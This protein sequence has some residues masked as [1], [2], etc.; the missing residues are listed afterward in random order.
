MNP[1]RRCEYCGGK[2]PTDSP[3]AK[4]CKESCRQLAYQKRKKESGANN[5]SGIESEP[6]IKLE[7][8]RLEK[9]DKP[10]EE[11]SEPVSNTP[12]IKKVS[13]E[14]QKTQQKT[15]SSNKFSDFPQD[16]FSMFDDDFL[17][18]NKNGIKTPDAPHSSEKKNNY[19]ASDYK[20][21]QRPS[22][23]GLTID[24]QMMYDLMYGSNNDDL[25]QEQ[26]EQADFNQQKEK[27]N[28]NLAPV[29]AQNNS[30]GWKPT[31]FA[32]PQPIEVKPVYEIKSKQ[33]Y[34]PE[35]NRQ[36]EESK[37]NIQKL[38]RFDY[39]ENMLYQIENQLV[40][41]LERICSTWYGRQPEIS[42]KIYTYRLT[43]NEWEVKKFD[44]LLALGTSLPIGTGLKLNYIKTDNASHDGQMKAICAKLESYRSLIAQ[45]KKRNIEIHQ[46]LQ[47]WEAKMT[48]KENI[49]TNKNEFENYVKQFEGWKQRKKLHDDKQITDREEFIKQQQRIIQLGEIPKMQ[50]P[51]QPEIMQQ[52][53]WVNTSE[54]KNT[55]QVRPVIE[56][57][58]PVQTPKPAQTIQPKTQRKIETNGMIV[59]SFDVHQYAEDIYPFDGRYG[60][61]LGHLSVS[62][63]MAVHG[64]PGMGKSVFCYRFAKHLADKYGRVLYIASEE[65]LGRTTEQKLE[66][67]NCK[68]PNLDLSNCR[69]LETI[70]ANVKK[71]DYKF[72][73]LD[74]LKHLG[75]DYA[76]YLELRNHYSNEAII[77][78]QQST[79]TGEMAGEQSIKH[80]IDVELSVS[81][82][83]A[84]V[85][86]TRA[87]HGQ[88]G[89]IF[90]IF[91]E[92]GRPSPNE[93]VAVI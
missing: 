12:E 63:E 37:T 45:L 62:F 78:V 28:P 33:I 8:F 39:E 68:S 57:P 44:E 46:R 17:E 6:A 64:R 35:S 24:Q 27:Q 92:K 10:Q 58:K 41:N 3:L 60:D 14:N 32:E 75:I 83:Y 20:H 88:S 84:E 25:F 70:F 67:L 61:F 2:L 50:Q 4:Y 79:K 15:F 85:G 74:S 30:G 77:S 13:Q 93:E 59:N 23:A 87:L 65:G 43:G 51:K 21:K 19:P 90:D 22:R 66:E 47:W 76:A 53:N 73:F 1:R 80:E 91:P 71:G 16:D 69:D 52:K 31:P 18:S 34:T 89:L 36:I 5:L 7:N 38:E 11:K 56:T 26:E 54:T 48:V 29:A 49:L 72:I 82:G 81:K 55:N 86:K 40:F 9:Q 42:E